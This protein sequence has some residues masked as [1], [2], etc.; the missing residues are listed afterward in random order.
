MTDFIKKNL[1]GAIALVGVVVL[2]F[3][4]MVGPRGNP[5]GAANNAT[6]TI[7]NPFNFSQGFCV[8]S[9][10]QT[11]VNI[12]GLITSSAA[13]TQSGAATFS[14]TLI[15]S[16]FTEGGGL[17]STSTALTAI[18]LFSSDV[19][20]ENVISVQPIQTTIAVTLPSIANSGLTAVGQKR[21]FLIV[22]AATSTN[23]VTF[24]GNA[25]TI[26]RVASSTV[27]SGGANT[28]KLLQ[29]GME[30]LTLWLATSTASMVAIFEPLQ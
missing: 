11:C 21:T 18:T 22:N 2:S 1:L 13:F 30:R 12:G 5:V 14:S 23:T 9:S 24:S 28:S 26:L 29:G 10:S 19:D 8:G 15:S 20:R 25:D 7:T 27:T 17:T 3:I 16:T 6:S 4:L